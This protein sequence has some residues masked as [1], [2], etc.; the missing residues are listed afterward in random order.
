LL[1]IS[2]LKVD[3]WD[4]SMPDLTIKL[5]QRFG[6]GKVY[7][8]SGYVDDKREVNIVKIIEDAA[9]L[10]LLLPSYLCTI[11]IGEG[12]GLWINDNYGPNTVNVDKSIDG[13]EYL[14]LDHFGADFN[15]TQKHL[16]KDYNRGDEYQDSKAINEHGQEVNSAKFKNVKSGIQALSATLAL[17]KQLFYTHGRQ[18]GYIKTLGKPDTEQEAFWIYVYFQGEGRAKRYLQSNSGFDFMKKAPNFM[19]QVNRLARERVAAWRYLQS[20]NIF[21]S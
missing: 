9:K 5:K 14:G 18:F 21:T 6:I 12:F 16:P 2:F 10:N 11:A 3:N 19:L 7:H 17:R 4:E 1:L 8:W 20:K 15:R 13:F